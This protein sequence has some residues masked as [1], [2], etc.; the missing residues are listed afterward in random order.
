MSS[1][2]KDNMGWASPI[3]FFENHNFDCILIN[4]GVWFVILFCY[5][6]LQ[7]EVVTLLRYFFDS[8]YIGIR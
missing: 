1:H 6:L 5:T 7:S 2:N 8:T 4:Q 3:L